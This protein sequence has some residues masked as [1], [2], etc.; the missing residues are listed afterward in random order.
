MLRSLRAA[1]AALATAA[2]AAGCGAAT[3]SNVV[4]IARPAGS[5]EDLP[6]L[7]R[8]T[9]PN[10]LR[11]IMQDHRAAD[12]AAIYLWVGTGVRYEKPDGLGYAHFQEHMLFKGTDKFGPG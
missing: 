1:L 7:T 12:V 9:L 6:P 8:E 11:L 5:D 2:L 3:S 4:T 10:G